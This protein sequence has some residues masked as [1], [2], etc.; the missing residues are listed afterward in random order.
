M[1]TQ[2]ISKILSIDIGGTHIKT[3]VLSKNGKLLSEYK[4]LP[5][6]QPA[7]PE[8]VVETI[9][10]L[11]KGL[12]FDVISAGFPGYI[13]NGVAI[14]A[15]NLGTEY[16]N[17]ISLADLLTKT[18]SKPARVVNDADMQGLGLV[19]GKG[20]E[21]V[22]TLGTGFGTAF[23]KDGELLPHLELAHHPIKGKK[24]YDAFI[25]EKALKKLGKKKWNKNLQFIL[26]VLKTVFNYD[27]LYLGG[28]N[29]EKINFKLDDNIKVVTN[30]EGIDGGAKLWKQ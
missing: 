26:S 4:K 14:T 19:S 1:A 18:F 2:K 20:F 17:N 8:A 13:K 22:V 9:K 28:G 25:G 10:T 29:A 24:D 5:T 30:I 12:E 7:T 27:T 23:L 16:W 15:P 6:P 11:T 21:M 3:S